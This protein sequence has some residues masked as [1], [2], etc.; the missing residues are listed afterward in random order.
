MSKTKSHPCFVNYNYVLFLSK[1]EAAYCWQQ[2]FL[3][4]HPYCG[5]VFKWLWLKYSQEED[6]AHNDSQLN[7]LKIVFWQVFWVFPNTLLLLLVLSQIHL[8][9]HHLQQSLEDCNLEWNCFIQG[10]VN[11]LLLAAANIKCNKIQS[12]RQN[13]FVCKEIKL[14]Y[15]NSNILHNKLNWRWNLQFISLYCTVK[16]SRYRALSLSLNDHI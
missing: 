12:S 8:G 1:K 16:S 6:K 10:P 4:C 3:K 13:C 7:D 11:R 9:D 15:L 5:T 14:K 2:L